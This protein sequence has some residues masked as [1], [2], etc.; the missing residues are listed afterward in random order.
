MRVL[1][2]IPLNLQAKIEKLKE[3]MAEQLKAPPFGPMNL[4]PIGPPFNNEMM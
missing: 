4:N 2:S 1:L 3:N